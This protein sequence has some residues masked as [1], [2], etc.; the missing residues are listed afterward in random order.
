MWVYETGTNEVKTKDFNN[1]E[2]W[3]GN[4]HERNLLLAVSLKCVFFMFAP[5]K[6]L[7]ISWNVNELMQGL[8]R[9]E[10]M[11]APLTSVRLKQKQWDSDL[12]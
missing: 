9:K 2:A 11:A 8:P 1:Y 6:T 7:D 12:F 4:R 10:V 5:L 3:Q